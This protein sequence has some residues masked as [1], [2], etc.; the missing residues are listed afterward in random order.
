MLYFTPQLDYFYIPFTLLLRYQSCRS[1]EPCKV[2]L[3]DKFLIQRDF[4]YVLT[5]GEVSDL[6]N[7]RDNKS[8]CATITFSFLFTIRE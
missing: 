5:L 6:P 3:V 7:S 1:I 4:D 2:V 8:S